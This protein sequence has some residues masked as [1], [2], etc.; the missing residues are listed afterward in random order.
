MRLAQVDGE[1]VTLQLGIH[2]DRLCRLL[3]E[4][5]TPLGWSCRRY[6]CGGVLYTALGLLHP[7]TRQFEYKDAPAAP[8]G[9]SVTDP[10]I[11]AANT[12]FWRAAGMWGICADLRG[13]PLLRLKTESVGVVPV[14]SA[15]GKTVESYRLAQPLHVECFGRDDAG[16]ITHVQLATAAG[17]KIVWPES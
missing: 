7:V 8:V 9:R 16:R 12:S 15:D 1:T 3:D 10:A 6:S 4:W 5:F 14:L 2:P 13:L 17:A 11:A